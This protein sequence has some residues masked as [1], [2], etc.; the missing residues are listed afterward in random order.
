MG[1]F[2]E[3]AICPESERAGFI[4]TF[5]AHALAGLLISS[6]RLLDPGVRVAMR[7]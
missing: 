3:G 7:T 1:L 5:Q 4:A 2:R 6:K